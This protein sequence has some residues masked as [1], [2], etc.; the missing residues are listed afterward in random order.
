MRTVCLATVAA[1]LC[2]SITNAQAAPW[3]VESYTINPGTFHSASQFDTTGDYV[4]VLECHEETGLF[5][6]YVES[7]YDW[8]TTAS[9]APDVP[10]VLN[11]GGDDVTDV[12]FYFDEKQ[13]GEGI[14]A[15]TADA[16]FG[17][18]L[19]RMI[20]MG[21]Y[22]AIGLTYFDRSASF[23]TEGLFDAVLSLSNSCL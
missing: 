13:L 10:T 6:F 20:G 12:K 3:S 5:E 8:D 19:D 1:L 9:Y 16:A 14:R 23:S 11:V 15:D 7:P 18:L 4:M 2:A 17:R 22:G 21:D